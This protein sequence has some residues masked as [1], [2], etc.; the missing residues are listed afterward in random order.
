M[1]YGPWKIWNGGECPVDDGVFVQV[2]WRSQTRVSIEN[3]GPIMAGGYEWSDLSSGSDIIA[4]R[5]VIEPEVTVD[6]IWIDSEGNTWVNNREG[7]RK[8][9]V[10][11]QGDTIKAEWADE[12]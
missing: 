2:Q 1:E 5:E 8:A 3:N 10:T 9:K 4:Y 12:T 11:V 6:Y 7:L